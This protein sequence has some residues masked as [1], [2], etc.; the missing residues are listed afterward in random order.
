MLKSRL[1]LHKFNH[2]V[3]KAF[4]N[5]ITWSDKRSNQLQSN[6]L[7]WSFLSVQSRLN[8]PE[9]TLNRLE[10]LFQRPGAGGNTLIYVCAAV[11]VFKQFSRNR[12]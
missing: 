12:V 8:L 4:I 5:I 1:S 10:M 2:C 7:L 9:T 3:L 6:I 11:K